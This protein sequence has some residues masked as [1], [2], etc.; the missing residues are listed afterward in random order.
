M[1]MVALIMRSWVFLMRAVAGFQSFILA[2]D[3]LILANGKM[4]IGYF[5]RAL[6]ATHK[7]LQAM[8]P[9]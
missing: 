9:R 3:V 5:A 2:D 7:Y 1:M 8:G 4:M 6:N